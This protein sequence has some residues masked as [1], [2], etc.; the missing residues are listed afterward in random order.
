MPI[1]YNNDIFINLSNKIH[2]FKYDYSLVNYITNNKKV[3]IVCPEHGIFLQRPDVH[4]R[5]GGCTK[6]VLKFNSEKYRQTVE[7][8]IKKSNKIHNFKYDYSLV[9]YINNKTKVNIVCPIHGIFTQEPRSHLNKSGCPKCDISHKSNNV[10]F[11]SKSINKHGDTYIYTNVNYINATT[12]ISLICKKHGEFLITPNNHLSGK[13]CPICK[14]S[15]GE[16][17][18]RLFLD[19]NNIKYIRQK[20]FNECR[21]KKNLLFDFYLPDYN[22]CIEYNGEQHYK[23]FRFEKNNERLFERILRDNIKKDFCIKNDIKLLIIKY[24]ENIID[25]IKNVIF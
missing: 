16:R 10:D 13:G 8:F 1:K 11:I 5:G 2:N 3:E 9:E 23:K 20:K 7:D 14:E 21:N 6:C 19:E 17:N 12:K 15:T 24:N 18:I 4:L 25:K 22:L